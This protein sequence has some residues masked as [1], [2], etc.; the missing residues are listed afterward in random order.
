VLATE[1]ES[2][3]EK[4]PA[5]PVASLSGVDEEPAELSFGL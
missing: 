4:K 3:V 5:K 1:L 2:L